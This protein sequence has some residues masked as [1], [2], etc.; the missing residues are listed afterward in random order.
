MKV[1]IFKYAGQVTMTGYE[2]LCEQIGSVKGNGSERALLI[3]ATPGGDPD[4]G[5]R[6]A[7]SLQHHYKEGFDAL[8]PRYCKSAGTLILMGAKRVFMADRSELG[9]LDIQIKKG[10][11]LYG[12]NSGLDINQAVD[13][14]K[15]EALTTF[16]SYLHKLSTLGLS[17]KVAAD[18]SAK[19]VSGLFNPIAAQIEPLRLAEMKRATNITYAYGRMLA[20]TGQNVKSRGLECSVLAYPSHSFVIDRKEAR[21]IFKTVNPPTDNLELLAQTFDKEFASNTNSASVKVEAETLDIS[22]GTEGTKHDERITILGTAQKSA[23]ETQPPLNES[24]ESDRRN[25]GRKQPPAR[26]RSGPKQ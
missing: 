11:E 15:E 20:E 7:R 25:Q 4:A 2:M 18:I 14:L 8:V 9:P 16:N 3:I 26:R 1:D 21:T 10:D 5:F 23:G 22:A 17:T 19:L 24:G 12:R 6:I 13:F